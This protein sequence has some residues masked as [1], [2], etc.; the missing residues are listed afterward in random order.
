MFLEKFC[1]HTAPPASP[2]TACMSGNGSR[3][4]RDINTP[5]EC[6]QLCQDD[7]TCTA[8]E[9]RKGYDYETTGRTTGQCFKW[10]KCTYFWPISGWTYTNCALPAEQGENFLLFHWHFEHTKTLFKTINDIK[11]K[12]RS[13]TRLVCPSIYPRFG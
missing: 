4:I 8:F 11:G 12:I 9:Y 3:M 5:E 10:V 2:N 1:D 7:P 6:A 13:D